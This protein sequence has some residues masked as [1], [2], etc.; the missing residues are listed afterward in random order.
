[1]KDCQTVEHLREKRVVLVRQPDRFG[2]LTL[3]LDRSDSFVQQSDASCS[4]MC[5]CL[6]LT[7]NDL[8]NLTIK[9]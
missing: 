5:F 4:V 3:S 9:I 2:S 7:V 1:M 8:P 6:Y